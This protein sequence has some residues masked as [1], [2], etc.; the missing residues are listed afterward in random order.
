M[1]LR[2]RAQKRYDEE[3]VPDDLSNFNVETTR[4]KGDITCHECNE[5]YQKTVKSL[6]NVSDGTSRVGCPYCKRRRRALARQ[7]TDTQFLAAAKK[8]HAHRALADGSHPYEYPD[9]P[10]RVPNHLDIRPMC[11][12]CGQIF[13]KTQKARDHLEG[14]GCQRCWGVKPWTETRLRQTIKEKV[15]DKFLTLVGL[16]PDEELCASSPLRFVCKAENHPTHKT[17][18]NYVNNETGPNCLRC[19]YILRGYNKQTDLADF[20]EKANAKHT[21]PETGVNPY[22][23]DMVTTEKVT[24]KDVIKIGCTACRDAGN[25]PYFEQV[26]N[27]HLQGHGCRRCNNRSF[28][29]ERPGRFYELNFY[30]PDGTFLF[31]KAGITN[32]LLA[33]RIYR[34]HCGARRSKLAFIIVPVADVYF[35]V[36]QDAAD[37]EQAVLAIRDDEN[38]QYVHHTSFHGSTELFQSNASPMKLGIDAG[39]IDPA[40]VNYYSNDDGDAPSFMGAEA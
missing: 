17:V 7:R 14:N 40:D 34:I 2:D 9:L 28:R 11:Y 29:P 32:L 36:G 16:P 3:R 8:A 23:Y 5:I 6:E 12:R 27:Y 13:P 1:S 15:L 19:S 22:F 24:Q 31:K 39:L 25:E 33:D 26:A 21:D 10:K 20:I 30:S 37:L 38:H 35:E 4:D 18:D